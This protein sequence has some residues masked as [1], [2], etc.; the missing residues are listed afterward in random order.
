M[1]AMA[2]SATLPNTH[3]FPA[4]RFFRASLI[5]LIF[6]SVCT[7]ALTG[8]LDIFTA[9]LAPAAVVYKAVRWWQGRP[10][11][12][13][14]RRATWLVIF[15]LAFF[16]VDIFLVS[17]LIV[18]NSANPPL[19]GALLS[20]VH[21]LIF[22]M[23]VRLYSATTDRDAIFLTMLAFAGILASAV[24]TVDTTFLFC[25][26]AF[27]IFGVATFV[28]LELRRASHGALDTAVQPGQSER[29]RQLNRALGMASL[30]VAL[31][32]IAIGGTLF[33]FFPRFSAGYL[34]R[35][36]FNPALMTGFNDDVELG[37]I[38][39][40]KKN[41]AIVMR[42]ETGEPVMYPRLRWRGIALANFDG[43]RWYSTERGAE[44]LSPNSDGWIFIGSGIPRGEA[45]APGLLYTVYLEPMASDAIFVP[46]KVV[47][48]RG[49]FNG[50][51]ESTSGSSRKTYLF[52]DA[53]GSLYNPFH[54]YT[55]VRYSGFSR[56]PVLDPVKLRA[57]GA[58]YPEDIKRKYLQLPVLDSRIAPLALQI[59]ARVQTAYDKAVT[60]ENYLRSRYGYTLNLSGKPGGD[61]LAHFLFEARAGHCEYFASAMTVMLRTL[62][63]PAREVNG[64]LP[65]E[66]NDLGGDYVVRAS[67]AHS[68]VEAYFPENGWVT[69]DPTPAG[70][71]YASGLLSRLEKY[72]DWISLTWNEWIISYDFAHQVVLAQNLKTSSR[73]WSESLRSWFDKKQQQA[74]GWMK[75]WEFQHSR[76]RYLLPVALV[77][78]LVILRADMIPEIIRRLKI[79]AQMRVGHSEDTNPQLAARLYSEL[80]RILDRRGIS[81]EQTQTAFEFVA[82]VGDARIAPVLREFTDI[83]GPARFGGAPCNAARLRELLAQV[84]LAM[85]SH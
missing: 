66:Y 77:L 42:V 37:Q 48:L 45:R 55:A 63:I 68:W 14:S 38:G 35:T 75:D 49:N 81:R 78:F 13:Q 51:S 53:A 19:Y 34:G 5:L 10:I 76:L 85:R 82:S 84:R 7:L 73:S 9:I 24:L 58:D 12:M 74:R 44:T 28:G 50:E 62:G 2:T 72:L 16:P 54:N 23:L 47:S 31:G 64:F 59:T 83:Y 33:F 15:Y 27:L 4:E 79:Y 1:P 40:I 29:E 17:R 60:L 21:F 20:A 46:G 36:S 25:F 70:P 3:V 69:F 80:L 65:G 67:D 52:R 18:A 11:E 39:E 22:V 61:P 30:S 71:A 57:A 43:K 32:A 56:L 6:S 8:K 41:T 26:F